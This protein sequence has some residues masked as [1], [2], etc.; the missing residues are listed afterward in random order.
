M[1][2][3]RK[4]F[5][6]YIS[7]FLFLFLPVLAY[8]DFDFSDDFF[9]SIQE[10]PDG[11]DGTPN[12]YGEE[13]ST[14]PA[15]Y[16]SEGHYI[17]GNNDSGD[18]S[19][20]FGSQALITDSDGNLVSVSFEDVY[21]ADGNF[22][23]SYD[24]MYS[25]DEDFK[26]EVE[27]RLAEFF[28]DLLEKT[29]EESLSELLS[30]YV[31]AL[32]EL[33]DAKETKV[34]GKTLEELEEKTAA[35][36]A[37]LE[38]QCSKFGY[39]WSLSE[40][41]NFGV[42]VNKEGRTVSHVGDP[43]IFASGDFVIDDEDILVRWKNT[44]FSVRRHYSSLEASD[45]V[46]PAGFFGAGWS[47]NL[48]SRIICCY[49]QD[50][51]D[52]KSAW[53][54]YVEKLSAYK[55]NIAEYLAEDADCS[56]IYDSMTELLQ[57]AEE[58]CGIVSEKAVLSDAVREKNRFV[59]Y[60]RF[61]TLAKAA[62][63]DTV[64]YC[65]DNGGF[66]VFR[67]D[68]EGLYRLL[69]CFEPCKLFLSETE[70]GYCVTYPLSGEK[71]FYSVYGLPLK[72][73]Y[74]GGEH[75]D[76]SYD[77]LS[78]I[79]SV[80][81]NG[82]K[83][84][85]LDWEGQKLTSV[86]DI[87]SGRSLSYDYEKG[88]LSSVTDW[89]GDKKAFA[90]NSLGLMSRQI[91]ADGSFVSIDYESKDGNWRPHMLR[92]EEGNCEY[93]SYNPEAKSVCHTNYEGG[94]SVFKYD[95]RGRTL[96]AD[97]SDGHFISYLYD[98]NGNLSAKTDNFGRISFSY[99]ASGNMT[100]KTYPDGSK[101]IWAYCDFGITSYTDRDGFTQRYSYNAKGKITDIYRAASLL[102][103]F[104]Y[105]DKGMLS[106]SWDCSGNRTVFAYDS[107]GNMTERSVFAPGK[108]KAAKREKWL[109]DSQGRVSSYTDALGR[110]TQYSY[111]S[112]CVK[113][114]SSD[115]LV[116]EKTYSAR[117][118]LLSD[119]VRD[120]KSG[121]TRTVFYEYD[122]N[123]KCNA[124]YIS[125]IDAFG[126][127]IEKKR[128][129]DYY[130]RPSG[131][132]SVFME[133]GL[134]SGENTAW[135]T[136]FDYASDGSLSNAKY[137]LFDVA[138]GRFLSQEKI[139]QYSHGLSESGSYESRQNCD[140]RL[141]VL[142]Y[143][144][145]GR[146]T[147]LSENNFLKKKNEYSSGG[148]LLRSKN[149]KND[150]HVYSYDS[151]FGFCRGSMEKDGLCSSFDT[152]DFYPDGRKKSYLDRSGMLTTFYYDEL[153]RLVRTLSPAG[154]LEKEYDSVDRLIGERIIDKKGKI[155]KEDSWLYDGRSVTHIS[156]D[157]YRET[158]FLN[159]F[160]EIVA[161]K[162][163][164][165]NTKTYR[166]DIFG[167]IVSETDAAARSTSYEY[168]SRGMLLCV[169]FPDGNFIR[170]DYDVFSCCTAAYDGQGQIWKKTYDGSSRLT[171][172]SERPF[173][174]TEFY[175]YNEYDEL[176]S[177]SVNG[178][179]LKDSHKK[180]CDAFGRLLACQNS[181]GQRA[182]FGYNPDA[183]PA[184][185][186]DF[187]GKK[188]QYQYSADKLSFSVFFSDGE[189]LLYEYDNAGNLV[190]AK[191]SVSDFEFT[192][193]K[194]GC[195]L[196]QSER[197]S[198]ESLSF[199]YDAGRNLCK[200]VGKKREI[201]YSWGKCGEMLSASE[202]ITCGERG[203]FSLV[204]FVY[205]D[206]GRETLRVYDSGES[207][208]SVYDAYGRQILRT[209]YASGG[210]LVFVEGS[211]Y[212]SAGRK[213]YA[214]DSDFC[215]TLYSYDDFGRISAVSY[216]YSDELSAQMKAAV[217]DAGLFYRNEQL[218]GALYS[219]PA[220]DYEALKKLCSQIGFASYQL[221]ALQSVLTEEF[222]YDGE[223]NLVSRKN[224][225]ATVFYSYDSENRLREWGRGCFAEYDANGNLIRKKT[226]TQEI[227][228]E[229][230]EMN[231][232]VTVSGRN[233][234]E[235]IFFHR[236]FTYDALGRRKSSYMSESGERTF[237]YIG[238][239][240]QLF[241]SEQIYSNK[242]LT[243]ASESTKN[244]TYSFDS[245]EHGRY[246]FI[247]DEI[248]S[249]AKSHNLSSRDSP[250][251][252][253]PLYDG[254]G[255]ILSYQTEGAAS[256]DGNV[257]LMTDM[258]GSVKG[259]ISADKLSTCYGYDVYG[260]PVA[261]ISD[262]AFVG[263]SYDSQTGLYD[264]GFR[265]YESAFARFST[266]DPA[267]AGKNC[268]AYCDGNPIS[269]YDESG[270]YP[271]EA[272]EQFM[273]DIGAGVLLGNGRTR[274]G[275]DSTGNIIDKTEFASQ[276]GCLVT[277]IAEA[278]TALTGVP[279]TNDY[280]NSVKECFND[281]LINWN[282]VSEI[283]GVSRDTIYTSLVTNEQKA[284][285]AKRTVNSFASDEMRALIDCMTKPIAE[286]NNPFIDNLKLNDAFAKINNSEIPVMIL[287]Q[288]NY[289]GSSLHFVGIGASV[290]TI[291]GV[292]MVE[293]T[294]TS[295][296]DTAKTLG[297]NRQELNWVV[298]DGK[299]YIPTV[300]INRIDTLTKAR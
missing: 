146:L 249:L 22:I 127:R 232:P 252:M 25:D 41:G 275:Y 247:D 188:R 86:K 222:S 171:S 147:E 38:E 238:F 5:F 138:T 106:E 221:S 284:H 253:Y 226:A 209:G 179:T 167:R 211:L 98:E 80:S 156:G 145:E 219:I 296:F 204:R 235:N 153:K 199:T 160:G 218:S 82:K 178:I 291:N 286:L 135:R 215:I 51:C 16:D 104:E 245:M 259:S 228:Y 168:D 103:H 290:H 272:I 8:A 213:Q 102:S 298:R 288:V 10:N 130:Y 233:F 260:S 89:E 201:S 269:F 169:R 166:R 68:S 187:N 49:E 23:Y 45:S 111:E 37:A 159:A 48:E 109:Y 207:M 206:M 161:V 177:V 273:Q 72:F 117:K 293:V 120:S 20:D 205:D 182:E 17:G 261:K 46:N 78:R 62:G 30:R 26:A 243:G 14:N 133:H 137:G 254:F 189:R 297:V 164:L 43:V 131:A 73:E 12:T 91:K 93:F 280:V 123:K 96:S 289:S 94:I 264:F 230:N 150:F 154:A 71:R 175:E 24:G 191:N 95:E 217:S 100:E 216:P 285:E 277:A 174:M 163:G 283:F 184:Y 200:I 67:K 152:T 83:A 28:E 54:D 248:S 143:D 292:K 50:Y 234:S 144:A 195:L 229:Y 295:K 192:Y 33:N 263:K 186:T 194:G 101:E 15:D 124:Q 149:G 122:R 27:S 278:L 140:G 250:C 270:L 241:A 136:E 210:T 44:S 279:V 110:K 66:I 151:D 87:I 19:S 225:Y 74:A 244:R 242:I 115:G 55:K 157:F 139:W 69:P 39:Q 287:A 9:D 220:E 128:L 170:Y 224:P 105:D 76:F 116:R 1:M 281:T 239:S 255:F 6:S 197:N 258:A 190:R 257:I 29:T 251:C 134:S 212:D 266:A 158:F 84:L 300:L 126:N 21:D 118:L 203:G 81:I 181:L 108:Q 42:I 31:D 125:G 196:S 64:I 142:Q 246:V 63:F 59:E 299:V 88:I 268:Y 227:F 112:H 58:S 52:E 202:K 60:G 11:W 18:D 92:D 256:C 79:S 85:A 77:S 107:L 90:Y 35:A 271:V 173:T 172:Y 155:I 70:D 141:E 65:H 121:E 214:I 75:I 180:T 185:L 53:L 40:S 240:Q 7:V 262:F 198:G 193:D 236:T 13:P 61:A 114:L 294:A 267:F 56:E 47:S 265:D 237:S 32:K 4:D 231:R 57:S 282:S 162:D 223:N 99:D 176:I 129:Y 36:R 119:S 183:S 132:K 97:Y 3:T 148:R 113:S 2:I 274:Y 165:G 276:Q 208:R 34:N